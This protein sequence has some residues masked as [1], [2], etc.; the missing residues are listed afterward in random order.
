MYPLD[1]DKTTF[2][3]EGENYCYKVMPFG[4][5]NA[6]ATYQRLMDK[7]FKDLIGNTTEVYI[8]DIVVMS[9]RAKDHPAA[10]SKVFDRIS[11]HNV[12]LN[13]EKYFFGVMAGKVLGFM[14]TQRG[15][16]ANLD[17]CEAILSM[18]SPSSLKEVQRLNGKFA[19]LS[20]SSQ[21]LPRRPNLCI[22]C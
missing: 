9:Q 19:T 18:R 15:I 16:E 2:M 5:K 13:L 8:D 11:A 6:G 17:K 22:H 1:Q 21:N 3:T 12:R 14:V 4:L 20:G 7:V 10:L